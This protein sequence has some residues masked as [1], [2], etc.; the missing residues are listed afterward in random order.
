MRK[1]EV[2]YFSG[3]GNSL[4]VARGI[5]GRLHGEL[6]PIASVADRETIEPDA[7]VIGITFPVY[8]ADA[9]NIVRRF[10]EK[11]GNTEGKYIFAVC[12]YG[13]GAGDSF[14]TLDGILRS[15]GAGLSAGFGIHMPQNAFHKPWEIKSLAYRQALK[16]IDFIVRSVEARRTGVFYS[17]VVIQAIM[18]PFQG[19]IRHMTSLAL[20]K[21]SSTPSP[22]GLTVEQLMPLCGSSFTVDAKCNGCGTC[23]RVCPVGNIEI[24]NKKPIWQNR[25]ENCLACFNWCPA[26][27]IHGP[28]ASSDY[29][30]RHPDVTAH[31]ISSH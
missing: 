6:I 29:R 16:R 8:Y 10:A 27:A 30:Y 2:Y 18:T 23:A 21:A 26:N 9:P 31:D 5:A 28:L 11:L 24:V 4:I 15:R 12:N 7:N 25:C 13:G 22:S 3:T 20:E 17:N 1:A 19:W 14:K